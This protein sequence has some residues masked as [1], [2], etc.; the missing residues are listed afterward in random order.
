MRKLHIVCIKEPRFV[1]NSFIRCT[2]F[3]D[4]VGRLNPR[5]GT[6]YYDLS[7]QLEV[8]ITYEAYSYGVR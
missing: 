5:T 6:P 1:I 4:Q 7:C 3:T 8:V 2:L